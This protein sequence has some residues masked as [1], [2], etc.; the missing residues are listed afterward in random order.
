MANLEINEDA[1]LLH[2]KIPIFVKL[3]LPIMLVGLIGVYIYSNLGVG[4]NVSFFYKIGSYKSPSKTVKD[5]TLYSSTVDMWNAQVYSLAIIVLAFSGIW[6]YVKIILML[7]CW[8]SK[9]KYL[10]FKHRARILET[11]DSIGKWSFFDG[12]FM[13]IMVVAYR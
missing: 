12:F 3:F 6:P 13:V 8:F 10:P 5:F 2:P 4:S 7:I 1:L 9:P 11:M